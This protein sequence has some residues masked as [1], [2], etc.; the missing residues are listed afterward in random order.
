MRIAEA[1]PSSYNKNWKKK[2]GGSRFPQGGPKLK[3]N[4]NIN[5]KKSSKEKKPKGKC[6]Q[7]YIDGHWK[8][9][10]NKYLEEL[11]DKK[12]K[13]KYDLLVLEAR[14]VKDD[15]SPWILIQGQLIMFVLVCRSLVLQ[16]SWLKE[17][18]CSEWELGRSF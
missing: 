15:T 5:N 11:R 10:Y 16:G 9:N 1:Q 12:K 3:K 13:G 18:S 7:C 14:L 6:F 8:R 4:K 2:T 17:S